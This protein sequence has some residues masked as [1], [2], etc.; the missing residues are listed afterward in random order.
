M[1]GKMDGGMEPRCIDRWMKV[2]EVLIYQV[3]GG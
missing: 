2:Q 3:R 1:G